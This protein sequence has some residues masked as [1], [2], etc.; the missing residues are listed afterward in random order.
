MRSLRIV[1]ERYGP[2]ALGDSHWEDSARFRAAASSATER[3]AV[4]PRS[5]VSYM[6]TAAAISGRA[7]R[8]GCGDG[9]PV[10]R[11]SIRCQSRCT[12]SL[13]EGDNGALLIATTA[14][15][16]SSLTGNSR[17][18]RFQAPARQFNPTALLRDRN[19][20]LWIGT[21]SRG[22][23]MYTREGRI[24]LR[25]PTVSRAITLDVSLRIVKAIF[26]WP[27]LMASTAFATSPFPRFLSKQ[28]LSNASFG[29][30]WRPGMAAFGL[31][32]LMA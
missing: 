30:S 24:C 3:T 6:R 16:D 21:Q 7:R 11:N 29:P 4:R 5:V 2:A 9:S 32:L 15:S 13:I 18:I 22:S 27:L 26:G 19:G 28:G 17:R 31:A 10:L 14:E 23:C 12:L 20:G 8:P 25:G 1:K